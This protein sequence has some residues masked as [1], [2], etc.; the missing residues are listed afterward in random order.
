MLERFQA[1]VAGVEPLPGI[2][3][4]LA[5]RI[6]EASRGSVKIS[7]KASSEWANP[8]GTLHGGVLCDLSDLAMGMSFGSTLDQAESFTTLEM[9]ISFLKP[10]WE[11]ELTAHGRVI[12]RGQTIGLAECEIFDDG[13]SLVAKASSTCM[14]LRGGSA[15]G[16]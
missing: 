3:Q 10:I 15:T 14:V 5:F 6:L 12:K 9:K 8:L 1:M 13:G 16:R 2:A 7:F 4:R 11:A